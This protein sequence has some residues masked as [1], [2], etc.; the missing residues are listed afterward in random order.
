MNRHIGRRQFL[1]GLAIVAFD[2]VGRTWR[3]AAHAATSCDVSIP[4]LDGELLVDA[5][6]LAAAADDFGHIVSETPVAVLRPGSV[7][8]V[9]ALV[10]FAHRHRVPVAM[11]GQG[12]TTYGQAQAAAGVV[13]DSRTLSTI[14][15][16]GADYAVV[17]AGVTWGD[18]L[19]SASAYGL[20]P[21]VLTDY[22][23]LS[24]GGVLQAG[25][26]GGHTNRLGLVADQVRELD[27]VTG[28]GQLV[29][30]S[31]SQHA[32]LF[33]AMLGGLGQCGIIVRAVVALAP[34]ASNARVF[35]LVYSDI[36]QYIADQALVSAD[37]RFDYLE[38][39]VIP[40]PGGG[41]QFLLEAASYYTPPQSPNDDA[42]LSDLSPD[43]PV[44]VDEYTFFDW[45]NRLEPVVEF[46]KQ[47]GLWTLPHPWIDLFL[48]A[49]QVTSL[50][51]DVLQT[52][53]TADTGNGPILL[54]P[55][56]RAHLTRPLIRVPDEPTV[57]LFSI[58]R[59][60]PT[61]PAVVD[62]MVA[63]NRA[64]FEQARSVGATW[65]PIGAV[66]LARTDWIA[67]FGPAWGAFA[68]A[69]AK[70]DPK[71]LLAPGQ[72]IFPSPPGC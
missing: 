6:S 20:A 50:V 28:R 46:L 44:S 60:A 5:D 34:A 45:Q 4:G 2:P 42:L 54:Y 69:K 17:D 19:R 47:A 32:K 53:T 1:A 59:T 49:S 22:L 10:D 40:A 30:C 64:I 58:L 61:D 15:E 55:F 52:L 68:S 51:S 26:I 48:P 65:Y 57:Y 66:G 29:R 39:Q 12:H 18:L 11:R 24:I 7:D 8:D 35:Q 14:H 56:Q 72:G 21:P 67:H 33:H 3:T 9:R 38:G 31:A 25:G 13:I 37:A 27:V 23:E 36:H 63:A 62:A 41:W 71:R 43:G 70:Y 16:I